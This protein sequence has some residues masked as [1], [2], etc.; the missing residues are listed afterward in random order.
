MSPAIITY[1]AGP[2]VIMVKYEHGHFGKHQIRIPFRTKYET[3]LGLIREKKNI[4]C[5]FSCS[6]Q[7]QKN[8]PKK[9]KKK[10]VWV[11]ISIMHCNKQF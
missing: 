6:R 7:P 8:Q 5:Y 11:G 4:L 1:D 2:Q 9:T 10:R 3:D